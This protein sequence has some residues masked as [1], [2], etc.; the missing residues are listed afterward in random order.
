[1]SYTKSPF[2]I[3]IDLD[4]LDDLTLSS[5][6]NVASQSSNISLNLDPITAPNK[7]VAETIEADNIMVGDISLKESLEK[8]QERLAILTPNLELEDRWVQLKSLRE[9][10]TK[11][12]KELLEKEQIWKTLNK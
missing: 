12:E 5:Y 6:P 4:D 2:D 7:V 3:E 1:M 10:Y 11:L 8:I 9:Q